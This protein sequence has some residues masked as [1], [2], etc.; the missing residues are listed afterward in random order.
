MGAIAL[1][2]CESS[3]QHATAHNVGNIS[4]LI[5]KAEESPRF[6]GGVVRRLEKYAWAQ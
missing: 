3:R 1:I 5:F 2:S 4:L 6:V